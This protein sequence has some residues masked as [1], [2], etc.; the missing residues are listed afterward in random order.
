MALI[1]GGSPADIPDGSKV[2]SDHEMWFR[3]GDRNTFKRT[4][5]PEVIGLH[6]TGGEGSAERVFRVLKK[7]R[8]SVHFVR[9]RDR[10]VQMAD[11]LS[12]SCAHIGS[13]RDR[14]ISLNKRT[15]GVEITCRGFATKAD[16]LGS[17]LRDRT[18]LDWSEPRD[19]YSD[20]IGGRKV[21]MASFEPDQVDDTIWLCETLCGLLNIPRVI[22]W[23]QVP[24][25]ESD[26]EKRLGIPDG[27]GGYLLPVFDRDVRRRRGRRTVFKGVLGHLHVHKTKYDPGTQLFRALWFEGFNPMGEKK[28]D[29]RTA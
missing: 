5:P 16:L 27:E 8:L 18:E 19:V 14:P 22:P 3:P 10:L 21:R 1:I 20:Y 25:I 4:L 6:W 29:W 24:E 12:T 2:F 23:Q 26:L 7:R 11:V 28:P 9:D 15:V 13:R 17:D